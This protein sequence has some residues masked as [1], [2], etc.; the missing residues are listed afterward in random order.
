MKRVDLEQILRDLKDNNPEI[1]KMA[2]KAI[3]KDPSCSGQFIASILKDADKP[4]AAAIYD[5]LFDDEK[6]YP[7]I[8]LEAA[9]DPDPRVRRQ[10]IRYLFR[11]GSFTVEDGIGWLNDNDPYVRRRVI[12]YLFWINDRS[13]LE[14]VIRLA[15]NDPDP[16]VR[17]DA[18]RLVGIWGSRKDIQHVIHTLDDR[19]PLV[20]VQAIRTMKRLTGEDFG[21]P[22]GVSDDEFEWIVAKWQG[23]WELM[24]ERI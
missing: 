15:V 4:T 17:K 19:S 1:K 8:F 24:R 2:A 12:S 23:W 18:L 20:R 21:E 9:A 11:R 14:S 6:D 13:V 3:L 16:M 5:V 7:E 10:A 22:L